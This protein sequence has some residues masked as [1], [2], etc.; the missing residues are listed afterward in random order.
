MT[1]PADG[2]RPPVNCPSIYD[3]TENTPAGTAA[4]DLENIISV[5]YYHNYLCVRVP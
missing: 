2:P 4:S 1:E 3:Y 5:N